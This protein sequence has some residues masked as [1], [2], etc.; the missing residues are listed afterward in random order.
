VYQVTEI[1]EDI[2]IVHTRSLKA[3]ADYVPVQ[4]W[5]SLDEEVTG[6]QSTQYVVSSAG[7]LAA[8]IAHT[9]VTA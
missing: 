7:Y 9:N 1:N 5:A 6:T 4:Y 2:T 3:S 8:V